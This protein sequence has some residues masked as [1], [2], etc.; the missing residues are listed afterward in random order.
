MAGVTQR[1]SGLRILHVI[2]SMGAGGAERQ[3]V[4]LCGGLCERGLEVHVAFFAEGQNLQ[5]LERSG[6]HAHFLRSDGNHAPTL[7]PR[8]L[9]LARRTR[10]DVIQTWLSMANVLGALVSRVVRV[11]WIYSE[12]TLPS[13][14]GNSAKVRFERWLTRQFAAAV[15]SNSEAGD[16]EWAPM[17]ASRTPRLVI[18]NPLPLREFERTPPGA[19]QEFGLPGDLPLVVY[20]GRLIVTKGVETLL[21]A[22]ALA[23]AERPLAALLVGE[24]ALQESLRARIHALGLE[25][26]VAAPGFRYDA[27]AWLKRGAVFVS[28]SHCEGMPNT[29]LEAMAAGCPAIVSD[30]PP[31]HE[32]LDDA[33]AIFV[34]QDDARGAADAILLTLGDPEAAAERARRARER[35]EAWSAGAVSAEWERLYERLI[36]QRAGSR[37]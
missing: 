24:G 36:S 29:V 37:R 28:L 12:V 31:H 20:V 22:I 21:E 5:L 35:T 32:I 17:L 7:L 11:P 8:L 18:R 33:S 14:L 34:R 3:L 9:G 10:P 1:P 30:I 16:A 4:Q 19:P 6:A 26:R 2:P 27:V 15:V 23:N 13:A 25:G